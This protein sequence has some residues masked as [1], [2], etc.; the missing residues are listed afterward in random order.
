MQSKTKSLTGLKISDADKGLVTAV[1]STFNVKD[2]DGDVTLP[3]AFVDGAEVRISAYNHTSWSGALP[4][5]KATIHADEEKA[6]FEGQFFL[7]TQMGADTFEVIK[8][9]GDLQEYSYGFDILE[10]EPGVHDGENVQ[11]LKAV[12][13]HEVSPVL[14]GAGIGTRTLAVKGRDQ[15]FSEH[16]ASVMADVDALTARAE[17]IK[18]M[19]EEKGKELGESAKTLLTGVDA[20]LTRLREVMASEPPSDTTKTDLTRE[21]ARHEARRVTGRN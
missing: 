3:G 19:R 20:A 16:A 4:V 2:H 11:F 12:K 15:K 14:L 13:V 5:G 7:D 10:A 21:L 9:M 1:F 18:S 8:N 6:W 17:E